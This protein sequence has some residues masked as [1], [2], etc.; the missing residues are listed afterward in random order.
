MTR[1]SDHA[2]AIE[3]ERDRLQA[4]MALANDERAQIARTRER[5]DARDDELLKFLEHANAL[6]VAG[7]NLANWY[8]GATE[9]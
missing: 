6:V 3:Q 4:R 1:P 2:Y 8:R 9:E 7:T 5:M